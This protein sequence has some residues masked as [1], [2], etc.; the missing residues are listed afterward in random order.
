ML[1]K[2]IASTETEGV[3]W[4]YLVANQITVDGNLRE[5]IQVYFL[6][7]FRRQPGAEIGHI[8]RSVGA[9]AIEVVSCQ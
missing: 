3:A 7:D 8:A 1:L 9:V 5:C 4:K 2:R 6:D